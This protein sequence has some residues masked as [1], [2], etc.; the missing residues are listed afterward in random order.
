MNIFLTA[1]HPL[2]G[3]AVGILDET[4]VDRAIVKELDIILR[5]MGHSVTVFNSEAA[6]STELFPFFDCLANGSIAFLVVG[7]L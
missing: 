6:T 2:Y 4:I 1:G 3:G 5:E 7:C